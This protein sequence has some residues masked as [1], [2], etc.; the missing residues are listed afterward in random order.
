MYVDARSLHGSLLERSGT[1]KR[2]WTTPFGVDTDVVERV[3]IF[4][5]RSSEYAIWLC[6]DTCEQ[7]G[8]LYTVKLTLASERLR[9]GRTDNAVM[10]LRMVL[11]TE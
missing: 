7:T 9:H 3:V 10:F 6:S 8:Y 5:S 2:P 4:P 11:G 1:Y